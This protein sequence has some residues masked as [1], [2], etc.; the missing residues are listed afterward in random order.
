MGGDDWVEE[1]TFQKLYAKAV[2]TNSDLVRA[3][4][5][6]FNEIPGELGHSQ[7]ET[8]EIADGLEGRP[9]TDGDRES[10]LVN[11]AVWFQ[12]F[13][14]ALFLENELWFPEHLAAQDNYVNKLILFYVQRF[15]IVREHLYHYRISFELHHEYPK[16][17]LAFRQAAH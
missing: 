3:F 4:V 5:D 17:A 2:A 11:G 8:F 1:T 13:R 6:E 15:A 9:L 7:T 14:R 12:L 16:C 10:I